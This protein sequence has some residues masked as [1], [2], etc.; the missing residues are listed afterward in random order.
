[1]DSEKVIIESIKPLLKDYLTFTRG[2]LP[3]DWVNVRDER[4]RDVERVQRE[5][6]D[7]DNSINM[8]T[9][10]NEEMEDKAMPS[11]KVWK[12]G[13]YE[14]VKDDIKENKEKIKE[15]SILN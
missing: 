14:E 3:K 6:E 8:A 2:K 7:L 9:K 5:I 4:Q 10:F 13:T 1:M 11:L 15:T 12:P